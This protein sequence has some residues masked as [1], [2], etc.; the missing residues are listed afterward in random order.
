MC[1]DLMTDEVAHPLKAASRVE[2][3]PV[4]AEGVGIGP[5]PDGAYEDD[6]IR[7]GLKGEAGGTLPLGDKIMATK[8]TVE[9]AGH[10]LDL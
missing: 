1:P 9:A 3:V 6:G 7:V 5:V 10:G 2:N 8:E 4:I